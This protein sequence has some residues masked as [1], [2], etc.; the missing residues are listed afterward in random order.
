M[1]K[2]GTLVPRDMARDLRL[3]SVNMRGLN[4]PIK[5]KRIMT[6]LAKSLSD[7]IFL[8]ETHVKDPNRHPA[9]LRKFPTFFLAPG[10]S[11]SRGVVILLAGNL[12][13]TLKEVLR[14]LRGCFI[15]V[16]GL[17]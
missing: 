3:L 12:Q 2:G 15:I 9:P 5:R 11:K 14:D 16:K 10:L 1:F 6:H 7:V 8:Q 13:F 4:N 17:L